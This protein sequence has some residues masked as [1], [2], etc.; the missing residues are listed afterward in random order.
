MS[1]FHFS[2]SSL[3]K[4]EGVDKRLQFLAKEVL[5]ISPIDFAITSGLRTL[6]EQQELFKQGKSKCDG[7]KIKSK[8]QLGLAIDICPVIDGKIDY[9]ATGELFFLNGL[10]YAKAK[11]MKAIYNDIKDIPGI[12]KKEFN[13][14]IRLGAF[15]DGNSIKNNKFIDGYHI[16]LV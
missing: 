2:Q 7:I 9:S 4:L 14:E 6:E 3:S 13:T 15:W 8:H 11:E 12:T 5:K 1:N 10:F 16:E